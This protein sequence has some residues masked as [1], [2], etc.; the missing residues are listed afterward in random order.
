MILIQYIRSVIYCV[1]LDIDCII[2][3]AFISG[4]SRP[5]FWHI[6]KSIRF[7]Q[8]GLFTPYLKHLVIKSPAFNTKKQKQ[9]NTGSHSV[10]WVFLSSL[11]F[12][13]NSHAR[14]SA[15]EKPKNKTNMWGRQLILSRPQVVFG[16]KW[17]E[18]E[19]SLFSV[20]WSPV[21]EQGYYWR[22]GQKGQSVGG[23][24]VLLIWFE[25]VA[26]WQRRKQT[27]RGRKGERKR[28]RRRKRRRH[29]VWRKHGDEW[30]MANISSESE[31][32]IYL[33]S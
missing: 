27:E 28:E 11:S 2:H 31:I 29:C 14:S 7:V 22:R 25:N 19:N 3:F 9:K 32:F 8:I 23:I 20:C 26:S 24:G 13:L 21:F 6:F 16:Q 4:K 10:F 12:P 15:T 30:R 18:N 17:M 5:Y 1:F 33:Q